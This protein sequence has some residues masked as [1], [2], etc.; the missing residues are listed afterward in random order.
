MA[1]LP[2]APGPGAV[3]GVPYVQREEVGAVMRPYEAVVV[4]TPTLESE[5]AYESVIV[6]LQK[7]ITDGGGVVRAVERWGR[8]RLAYPIERQHDGYYVLLQ[9]DSEPAVTKELDRVLRI[10]D[11]VLRHLVV[12]RHE[13]AEDQ[14]P[15]AVAVG[16]E[17][18]PEP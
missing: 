8:R 17:G 10:T 4:L 14:A 2:P 5:E 7:V 6:R 3:P 9:F 13:D 15:E 16:E 1:S 12:R 18:S 11:A